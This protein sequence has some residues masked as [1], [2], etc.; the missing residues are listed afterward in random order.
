VGAPGEVERIVGRYLAVV[1]RLVPGRVVGF[2]VVGST[3]LGTYRSGKSDVDFVAVVDGELSTGELRRLRAVHAITAGRSGLPSL[4]RGRWKFP[5]NCNGAYVDAADLGRP[6]TKITPLAS[7][8][9]TTFAVGKGFDVNPVG[10][11]LLTHHG[12]TIRGPEPQTLGLDPEDDI[13]RSWTLGNLD[14]F[15]GPWARK[16]LHRRRHP[17]MT[18]VAV[19]ASA[20]MHHTVATG[21]VISKEAAGDYALATFAE[22]W[23][24]LIEDALARRLSQRRRGRWQPDRARE[25]ERAEFMLQLVDDAHTLGVEPVGATRPPAR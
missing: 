20:R 6:V 12:L 2:Y 9:G 17:R 14:F 10:W 8:S 21:N 16:V 18:S 24:P 19:L 22:R 15:W 1:D 4:L 25:R 23:H 5:G 11:H 13:L 3:A 7:H